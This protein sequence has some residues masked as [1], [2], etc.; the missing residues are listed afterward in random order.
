M[1]PIFQLRLGGRLGSGRQY[2]SYVSLVDEVQALRFLLTEKMS[3]GR[4]HQHTRPV[5]NA[6]ATK[7][8]GE[9]SAS[10]DGVL[11]PGP[12]PADHIRRPRPRSSAAIRSC[13]GDWG[14]RLRLRASDIERPAGGVWPVE[15]PQ[16]LV[17]QDV[18]I[19]A[20]DA[21]RQESFVPASV[22]RTRVS[23][24][25][26]R[27]GRD[28]YAGHFRSRRRG[29]RAGSGQRRPGARGGR[30]PPR[31]PP[32]PFHAQPA[33]ADAGVHI[34]LQERTITTERRR[35]GRVHGGEPRQIARRERGRPSLVEA[36]Q[37]GGPVGDGQG[38]FGRR[39][40]R[41]RW[42]PPTKAQ[43]TRRPPG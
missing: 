26:V 30:S 41:S 27:P 15:L 33:S 31:R 7:A 43:P 29:R 34:A 1:V 39:R 21:I 18:A 35:S 13:R 17:G 40:R 5:T 14:N 32:D 11:G 28:R 19:Q 38:T 3:P 4:W 9:G 12:G 20:T 23:R 16:R 42:R 10:F 6:E 25:D 2:W 37:H 24:H 8:L 22:V 36:S